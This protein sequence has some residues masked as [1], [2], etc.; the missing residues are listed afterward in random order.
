VERADNKTPDTGG[1]LSDIDNLFGEDEDDDFK[2]AIAESLKLSTGEIGDGKAE[3][4]YCRRVSAGVKEE[5]VQVKE[6]GGD[7]P[8]Q[9]EE[10]GVEPKLSTS[11][12]VVEGSVLTSEVKDDGE[13]VFKSKESTSDEKTKKKIEDHEDM[14]DIPGA[15]RLKIVFDR[16]NNTTKYI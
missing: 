1:E 15:K 7:K 6:Q 11:E 3:V 2:K 16:V 4:A 13:D 9:S 12:K 10:K 8:P 14:V 5:V